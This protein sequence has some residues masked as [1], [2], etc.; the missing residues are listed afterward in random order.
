MGTRSA[1]G[2]FDSCI[3]ISEKDGHFLVLE[4]AKTDIARKNGGGTPETFYWKDF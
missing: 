2:V 4:I 3:G 1:A